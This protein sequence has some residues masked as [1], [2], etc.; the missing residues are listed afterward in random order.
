VRK[1]RALAR[2]GDTFAAHWDQW[3]QEWVSYCARETPER[4]AT[5]RLF[6]AKPD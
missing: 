1:H 6:S 2:D 4:W 3:Q 5:I